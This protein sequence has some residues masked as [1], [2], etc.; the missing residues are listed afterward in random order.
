MSDYTVFVFL[1]SA[2]RHKHS[3]GKHTGVTLFFMLLSIFL[4]DM[5]NGD[6]HLPLCGL[7]FVQNAFLPPHNRTI[8]IWE[9]RVKCCDGCLLANLTS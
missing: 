4:P 8:S 9:F 5:F 2:H 3:C 1:K 7:M 6:G